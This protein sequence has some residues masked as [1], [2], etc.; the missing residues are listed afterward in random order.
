VKTVARLRDGPAAPGRDWWAFIHP[1]LC[2][3]YQRADGGL[4]H[5]LRYSVD[6][7][8]ERGNEMDARRV[9][10]GESGFACLPCLPCSGIPRSGAKSQARKRGK[11][12]KLGNEGQIRVRGRDDGWLRLACALR[13]ARHIPCLVLPCPATSKPRRRGPPP[14]SCY[15]WAGGGAIRLCATRGTRLAILLVRSGDMTSR[16]M[17]LDAECFNL[18]KVP[19]AS[20]ESIT[21]V[22]VGCRSGTTAV[23]ACRWGFRNP[24]PTLYVHGCAEACPYCLPNWFGQADERRC[25]TRWCDGRGP[26]GP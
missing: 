6:T 17:G 13:L 18:N 10:T 1:S 26:R 8:G 16:A 3:V 12:S 24:P 2:G 9:M 20:L 22:P 21:P 7:S 4:P 23:G 15:R 14:F 25:G 19:K 5:A 11:R